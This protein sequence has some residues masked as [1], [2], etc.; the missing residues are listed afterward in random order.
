MCFVS[1]VFTVR[2][3]PVRTGLISLIAEFF[4]VLFHFSRY[5][6]TH[7]Y[8]CPPPSETR[9][10]KLPSFVWT[11][12][13]LLRCFFFGLRVCLR[14]RIVFFWDPIIYSVNGKQ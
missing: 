7:V 9:R 4:Y 14:V 13:D 5:A 1:V 10:I 3:I 2:F 8:P 11:D 12:H 6:P